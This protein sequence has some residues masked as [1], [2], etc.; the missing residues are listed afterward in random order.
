MSRRL[1]CNSVSVSRDPAIPG[2]SK[3]ATRLA[4]SF[5]QS[6]KNKDIAPETYLHLSQKQKFLPF[7]FLEKKMLTIQ[8]AV[9]SQDDA[10]NW[11]F[12]LTR[13]IDRHAGQRVHRLAAILELDAGS[14]G[15]GRL[16]LQ[17]PGPLDL[18]NEL[19]KKSFCAIT[20]SALD[21]RRRKPGQTVYPI[22][23]GHMTLNAIVG[24]PA[25]GKNAEEAHGRPA[26]TEEEPSAAIRPDA[27][28]T[29]ADW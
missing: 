25:E 9:V 10:K 28:R 14:G 26:Q 19:K 13:S 11:R 23:A 20:R 4:W 21:R 6:I 18:D 2:R 3:T 1:W 8:N 5:I 29:A 17:S 27:L 7:N 15:S 12:S 24:P 22:T 16:I